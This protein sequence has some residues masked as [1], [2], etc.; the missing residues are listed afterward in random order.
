[1]LVTRHGFLSS[2]KPPRPS[3]PRNGESRAPQVGNPGGLMAGDRQD[4]GCL[5]ACPQSRYGAMLGVTLRFGSHQPTVRVR[6]V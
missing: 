3:R 1:M 6:F 5:T 2:A 4:L